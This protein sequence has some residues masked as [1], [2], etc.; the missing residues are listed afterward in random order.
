MD[1]GRI[2]AQLA[3]VLVTVWSLPQIELTNETLMIAMLNGNDT[4]I[5]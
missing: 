4:V 1:H 3:V 5:E 2:V